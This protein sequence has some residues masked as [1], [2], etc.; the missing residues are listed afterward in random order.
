MAMYE[1]QE[2]CYYSVLDVDVDASPSVIVK[3]YR[4][5]ALKYHPDKNPDAEPEQFQAITEA[6]EVLSDPEKRRL[7]DHYG[8]SLK[9]RL[10]ETFAQLAPL[11][12]SFATGLIG[13]SARTYSGAF[14][15]RVM[16]GWELCL[17][18]V[19]GMYYCYQPASAQTSAKPQVKPKRE[20]VSVSDYVT[21]T[22]MGLLMG[23]FTG[24]AATSVVVFCKAVVLGS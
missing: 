8:P 12:L 14:S 24:W 10:G 2:P 16:F 6:Y 22:S 4:S 20:V 15:M 3:A 17:M 23:N 1:V 9:P 11:L 18:G 21:I 13:S 5:M 7:Y 19:A